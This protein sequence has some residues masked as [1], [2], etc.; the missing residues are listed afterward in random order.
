MPRYPAEIFILYYNF[1]AC[2]HFKQF[3][4]SHELI[5]F[6]QYCP[7]TATNFTT[8]LKLMSFLGLVQKLLILL[9]K[10]VMPKVWMKSN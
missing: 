5:Y 6:L 9:E 8:Q 4:E 7:E 2:L 10:T 1:M 3:K